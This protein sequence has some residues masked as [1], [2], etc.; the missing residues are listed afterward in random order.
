MAVFAYSVDDDVKVDNPV[1]FL[2]R[3]TETDYEISLDDDWD[4]PHKPIKDKTEFL[5]EYAL[6]NDL[7]FVVFGD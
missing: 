5:K 1:D 6:L 4:L 7:P 2:N 3:D